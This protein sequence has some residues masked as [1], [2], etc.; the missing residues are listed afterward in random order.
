MIYDDWNIMWHDILEFFKGNKT[1]KK[2]FQEIKKI[3]DPY[4]DRQTFNRILEFS[5][6]LSLS[7][8]EK[9]NSSSREMIIKDV[10][11]EYRI[12]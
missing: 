7:L 4:N 6:K 1:Y 10:V 2:S 11:N 5:N 12:R 9:N 3:V 8:S